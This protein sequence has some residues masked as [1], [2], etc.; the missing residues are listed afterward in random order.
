MSQSRP[1]SLTDE[2]MRDLF[3]YAGN[4]HPDDRGPFIEAVAAKLCDQPEIGD[5]VV[6]RT[7]R[8]LLPQFLVQ[9][10]GPEHKPTRWDRRPRVWRA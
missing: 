10:R 3:R 6:A 2:A 7:C 4:L 8:A 5:G 1:L 9:P